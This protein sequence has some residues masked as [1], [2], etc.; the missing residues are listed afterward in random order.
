M[1]VYLENNI[2]IDHSI[3]IN[4]STTERNTNFCY[5]RASNPVTTYPGHGTVTLKQ[6]A[7]AL[8]KLET[9]I[10]FQEQMLLVKITYFFGKIFSLNHI[11]TL[12]RRSSRYVTV[13]KS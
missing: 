5:Q 12:K 3:S 9:K 2:G 6:I 7:S 13:S 4:V 11:L 1:E 10:S 8:N